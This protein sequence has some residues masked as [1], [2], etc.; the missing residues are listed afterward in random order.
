MK[1]AFVWLT[2]NVKNFQEKLGVFH[3]LFWFSHYLAITK[4]CKKPG[5]KNGR[6]I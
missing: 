6:F 4:E 2:G 5:K 1:P 3:I